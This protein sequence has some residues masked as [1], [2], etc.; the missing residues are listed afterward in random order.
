MARSSAASRVYLVDGSGYIF[1]AYHALPPLTRPSDALP[2]GAVRGFCAMLFKLLRDMDPP[3]SHLGVLF[4]TSAPTFRTRL[5]AAYKANRPPPPDDLVPQFPLVHAACKAFGVFS[6]RQDGVEA[7]DLI[8][9]YAAQARAAGHEVTIVSS[10]KDLMQLVGDGVDMLDTMKNRQIG[11]A[12][13]QEKFGVPPAKVREVQALAGDSSDNIAGVPGIGVKTAAELITAHGDLETLLRKADA[14]AQPKRRENLLAHADAARRAYALVTLKRDVQGLPPLA[15]LACRPPEAA[16]LLGFLKALEFATMVSRMA[17]AWGWEEAAYAPQADYASAA[18]AGGAQETGGAAAAQDETA[19]E[20]DSYVCITDKR[21]L[22]EW[23]EAAQAQGYVALDTETS[24]LQAADAELVGLSLALAPNRAAY[25]PLAHRKREGDAEGA[26]LA[27]QLPRAEVLEMLRPLLAGEDVLKILH[28]AKF[29]MLVLRQQACALAPLDDT[30]LLSYVLDAGRGGHG[31]DALALRYFAHAMLSY[32]ELVGR[33]RKQ[34]GFQDV[35]LAEA[36]RYAAEDADAC[37]RLWLRLKPRLHAAGLSSVYATLERPLVPVLVEMEAAGV[38]LDERAL[39]SL[40]DE[41]AAKMQ[42]MEGSIHKLAGQEFNLASPAQLGSILFEHMGIAGGRKTKTGA[43][44]TTARELEDLSAQGHV[45]AEKILEWRALAKL[46]STY[47]DALPQHVSARDQR[48]HS[49]YALAS[50]STGRLSSSDP[51]LQNIPIRSE[52]GRRIRR[53]FVAP[54]GR[55]L[56]SA[57]YSQIELRVLA[58]MA[59]IPALKRAFAAGED[60]HA[61]T[62][63]ELFGSASAAEG[64]RRAKA[65]NYGII[66]GM[67]AFGLARQLSIGRDEAGR[68]I[69]AY[70]EKFPG[71]DA[72]MKAQ[73]QKLADG[74][75]VE[76][77]FGRRVHYDIKAARSAAERGFLERA[78]INAPI[79]GTAAD[80]M[81]RAMI[82]LHGKLARAALDAQLLLQVHDELVLECAAGEIEK[83][84]ALVK[85]CMED[86]CQ[87]AVQLSVP[88]V[89]ELGWG[90]NWDAAHP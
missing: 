62:A 15:K 61:H 29:D 58:H 2:V 49:S 88:L 78:A 82:H 24:S 76:T 74:Q 43:W 56:L 84:A 3:A 8:A 39:K 30:M 87:P 17:A 33:G 89:V 52:D 28:N 57:D 70:F 21:V 73:K 67:S 80:I 1:R 10:D 40:S 11:P 37:L 53:A 19:F 85:T 63:A 47:A 31:L 41:F 23:I 4:D 60:I 65:I 9:S 71:I 13:V 5:D 68:Y 64:R 54:Q 51:N 32:K 34:T 69:R 20:R 86:A 45:I 16:G 35:P 14:I 90:E 46:R 12:E 25:V 66:Y 26:P 59:D 44:S 83:L 7:D 6:Y 77:L 27:G 72:Y 75:A 48:V 81:R 79:Q 22:A 55:L 42:T 36:T 50:T 18:A 38:A